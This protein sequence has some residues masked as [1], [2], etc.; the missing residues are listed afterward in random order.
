MYEESF[1]TPLLVRWPGVTKPGSVNDEP[2]AE[3]RLRRD[4]PR[5]RRR[6]RCPPTCRAAASCRCSKGETPADWRKSVYYHYYEF[7]QPHHV[8]P[9]YGV[10]T[11]RYKLIHFY[12]IDEWE[13]FDLE[14]DPHELK[15]VYDDPAYADG[16]HGAEEGAD[17]AEGAVQG[18]RQG[19]PI[20]ARPSPAA[21]DGEGKGKKAKAKQHHSR[22]QTWSRRTAAHG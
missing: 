4:V 16:R 20:P 1:R 11:D 14:N 15:S 5:H 2:G 3:P 19:R 8:Q 22:D 7:P 6:R 17:A 21:A 10:R 18:R 12:T 9:H 13:L